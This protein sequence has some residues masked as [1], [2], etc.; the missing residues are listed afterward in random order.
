VNSL[1]G[2]AGEFDSLFIKFGGSLWDMR[3]NNAGKLG[4]GSFNN[5]NTPEEIVSNNV[6]AVAAGGSHSLFIKSEGSLWGMGDDA[7][8]E[9]GDGWSSSYS[10]V[11]EPEKLPPAWL[12]GT[13]FS[14]GTYWLLW[15]TNAALPLSQWTP[16]WTNTVVHRGPNNFSAP[17]PD[18]LLS[19][20]PQ[21]FYLL[22][23][24]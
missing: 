2:P 24:P 16:V 18:D 14:P 7:E 10:L 13:C 11:P 6:V 15:S 17:L 9:L 19:H 20:D 5:A 23:A 1:F 22:Q 21:R 8:G 4:N 3:N 12:R